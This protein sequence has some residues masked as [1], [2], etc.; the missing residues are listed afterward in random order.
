MTPTT[1][2]PERE[3]SSM[4]SMMQEIIQDVR[5]K[6]EA[7]ALER[8]RALDETRTAL[9]QRDAEV[10]TMKDTI[11]SMR[12][13]A[14]LGVMAELRET[15]MEL[16]ETRKDL[17]SARME[18]DAVRED[19]R[20]KKERLREVEE[21]L[22]KRLEEEVRR[23][24]VSGRIERK[25]YDANGE[26]E[27]AIWKAAT[28]RSIEARYRAELDDARK[29]YEIKIRELQSELTRVEAMR[30]ALEGENSALARRSDALERRLERDRVALADATS[31]L[32]TR[33]E[34]INTLRRRIE[35]VESREEETRLELRKAV[36]AARAAMMVAPPPLEPKVKTPERVVVPE[37]VE[38]LTKTTETLTKSTVA[39]L[40]AKF[41]TPPVSPLPRT[42]VGARRAALDEIQR[43]LREL[44]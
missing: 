12:R 3:E 33:G 15:R 24:R 22:R 23:V 32:E 8:E 38:P 42:P 39:A 1:S 34:L 4:M 25:P 7:N 17:V 36:E 27:K 21:S 30:D 20:E 18:H 10:S 43:E 41:D 29:D 44:A 9:A 26:G 14:E 40:A 37:T 35:S 16:D 6:L 31:A 19:L 13:D 28:E 5:A 11:A 2:M